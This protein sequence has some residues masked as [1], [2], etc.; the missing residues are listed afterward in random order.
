MGASFNLLLQSM[1][2]C[3]NNISVTFNL[4]ETNCLTAFLSLHVLISTSQILSPLLLFSDTVQQFRQ[5]CV[6][7]SI[8]A[9]SGAG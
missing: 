1:S 7:W 5:L 4:R 2:V 8:H 3:H 9:P 6:D